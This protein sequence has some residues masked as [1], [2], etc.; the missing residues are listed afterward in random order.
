MFNHYNTID[1]LMSE[2]GFNFTNSTISGHHIL[3]KHKNGKMYIC[4]LVKDKNGYFLDK[5]KSYKNK[6][7]AILTM[8][9]LVIEQQEKK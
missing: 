4:H 5:C 2:N 1:K 8:I 7:E 9:K 3:S 6:G